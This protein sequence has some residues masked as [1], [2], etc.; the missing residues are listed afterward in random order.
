ML[1][2][3]AVRPRR[4]RV[5]AILIAAAVAAAGGLLAQGAGATVII[6][7]HSDPAGDPAEFSYHLDLSGGRP[8]ADFVLHDNEE[9]GFGRLEAGTVVAS[10]GPRAGWRVA[11]IQCTG[12]DLSHIAIDVAAGRVVL[13]HDVTDDQICSFTYR[14]VAAT[15][16]GPA[17]SAPASRSSNTGLAPAPPRRAIPLVVKPRKAALLTVFPRRRA[18]TA[19]VNIVRR[20]LIKTQLL[21]RGRLV[22][23]SRVVRPAGTYDVTIPLA[24]SLV[25]QL[26]REGRKRV[27]MSIKMVVVPRP[28]ATSV[29]R[30]GVIVPL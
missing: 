9:K 14:R 1:I 7:N 26:R 23:I 28:G 17:S 12:S 2:E 21:W 27:T 5:R 29:F 6:Q 11:D 24:P 25:R 30:Y 13:Q 8:P 15:G 3:R 16:S 19:R 22:G 10:A 4:T 18:A 20:S